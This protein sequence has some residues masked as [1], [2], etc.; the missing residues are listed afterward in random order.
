MLL[1]LVSNFHSLAPAFFS[2]HNTM[3]KK[4]IFQPFMFSTTDNDTLLPLDRLLQFE[5]LLTNSTVPY[6]VSVYGGTSHGFAVRANVT[7]PKQRF[8]KEE[9]FF[10]AVRF[11]QSWA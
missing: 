3:K 4:I 9:A 2:T 11:F 10:Q 7:D 5:T 1:L 6:S 8:G